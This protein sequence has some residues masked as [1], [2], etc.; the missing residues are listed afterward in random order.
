VL[1]GRAAVFSGA[2]LKD[3]QLAGPGDFIYIPAGLPHLPVNTSA[4]EK[5]VAVVPRTD[6]S[7]QESVVL[8][9][10]LDSLPHVVG[11]PGAAG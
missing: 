9:P 11:A 5:C 4:T 10:E 8:M 7:E 3:R 6:P 1:S 2:G